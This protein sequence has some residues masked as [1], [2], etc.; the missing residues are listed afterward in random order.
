MEQQMKIF[1]E[2]NQEKIEEFEK[3]GIDKNQKILKVYSFRIF[4]KKSQIFL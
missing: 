4:K 3:F 2:K 1:V